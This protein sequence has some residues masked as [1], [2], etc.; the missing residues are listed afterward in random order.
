MKTYDLRSDTITKPTEGMRK[1]MYDAEVGD[2]V[3]SEDPSVNKL[4]EVAAE[5]TGKQAAIFLTSGTMGNLIPMYILCGRGNEVIAHRRAHILHFELAGV[6][7]IAGAMPVAIEGEKG[8]LKPDAIEKVI[9]PGVYSMPKTKLIEIENTHN[10]EG[11]TCY[12][13]DDLAAVR[14]VAKRHN[15]YVHMDG[16]RVFNAAT[17]T[18]LTAKEICSYTDTV[19][20]CLSKGLGAP[21]G[22]LLCGDEATVAEARRVRKVLGGGMRQA[23]VLAAAGLYA[24]ENNIERL[25]E[26]HEHA[27]MIAD[28]LRATDW[29]VLAP[30]ETNIVYFSTPGHQSGEVR[31]ALAEQGIRCNATGPETIRLVASLEISKEDT[32]EVC[33]I[34]SKLKL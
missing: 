24:L 6:A 12:A 23:G 9:R 30:V 17:A 8:I 21:V 3:Y 1:A 33:E 31:D 26:D 18:G 34:I 27:A 29:A 19:T 20:F 14:T 15:I 10:L 7:A 4:Q 22:S 2:D 16:A 5:I 32:R 25:G 11:G 13:K 28:A